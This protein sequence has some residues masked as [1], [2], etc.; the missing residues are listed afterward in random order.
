MKRRDKEKTFSSNEIAGRGPLSFNG[1]MLVLAEYD[2]LSPMED[3]SLNH[4]EVWVSIAR[5]CFAMRNN[6]VLSR[7][8]NGL[9]VFLEQIRIL[10]ERIF[11]YSL[12]L[13]VKLDFK[14]ERAYW[15]CKDCRLF[16][17]GRGTCDKGLICG[18][19]MVDAISAVNGEPKLLP[20][21]PMEAISLVKEPVL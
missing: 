18:L 16:G 7:V 12:E 19:S 1:G 3:V 6:K 13:S 14:A 20:S 8:T 17:H 4:L 21:R 15:I 11:D 2:G 9:E 5:L 10:T